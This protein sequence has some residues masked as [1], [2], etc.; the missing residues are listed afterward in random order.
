LFWLSWLSP[1][2][3]VRL[4][5]AFAGEQWWVFALFAG[6][7]VA[8]VAA[9]YMLSA[10]RDLG[11][12][13]LPQRL[14]PATASPSLRSPLALAWRLHRGALLAWTAGFAAFGIGLGAVAQSISRFLEV[15]QLQEWAIQ[16]GAQDA[17]DAY[18]FTIMYVLAQVVSAYALMATLRMRSEETE[19]RAEAVLAALGLTVGLLSGLSVGDVGG[20]L[21]RLFGRTMA[22]LPAVW[23][24][25][26]IAAAAYGLVPR[27]AAAL[28]WSA[29]ALF[30]AL[31]LAWELRQVSTSVFG[32]SP[33][34]YV[35]WAAPITVKPLIWLTAVAAALIA[36]GLVGFRRR[37]IG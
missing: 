2:G 5:R 7:I 6:L 11:A 35:H 21:P 22:A 13:F 27:F 12:G 37:D 32:L 4:T 29:L 36:P 1:L 20:E 28:S 24:M 26:G 8:L 30:F 18:L 17:G 15:P 16:A 25:T 23:V 33:F 31:E 9:A 14:G 34:A 3:W 10:R 19:G